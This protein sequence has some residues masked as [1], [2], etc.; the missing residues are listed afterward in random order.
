MITKK[1][2]WGLVR[3]Q[4]LICSGFIKDLLLDF[5][6]SRIAG[7]GHNPAPFNQTKKHFGLLSRI[8]E[9]LFGSFTSIACRCSGVFGCDLHIIPMGRIS[10]YNL[11]NRG[12]K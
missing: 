11:L 3:Y 1:G 8:R 4:I 2:L 12:E 6:F 7:F 5:H 10:I 9:T